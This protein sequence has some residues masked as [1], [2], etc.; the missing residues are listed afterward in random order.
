MLEALRPGGTLVHRID[1]RDHG[2]FRGQH[3]LTFLTLPDAIYTRMTRNSGRPNRVLF[4][5]Y[6]DWAARSRARTKLLVSRLVG[7][8][9]DLDPA[10]WE[11]LDPAL[12]RRAEAAVQEIRPKLALRFRAMSES[13]FAVA[14]CIL[15]AQKPGVE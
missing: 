11:N 4:P 12:R 2:M 6:R 8:D 5:D 9:R 7:V 3:P 13:E 14:G 15:V 10:P 1:L